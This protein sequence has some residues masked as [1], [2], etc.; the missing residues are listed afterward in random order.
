MIGRFVLLLIVGV[1]LVSLPI[2]LDLPRPCLPKILCRRQQ[3]SSAVGC[4]CPRRRDG[5]AV[6]R[7]RTR[8]RR[9]VIRSSARGCYHSQSRTELGP[10]S[11]SGMTIS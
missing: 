1:L 5:S 11:C 4:R 9:P 10:R 7:R 3:V 8:P 2:A 6:R